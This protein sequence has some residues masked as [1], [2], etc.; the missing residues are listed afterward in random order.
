MTTWELPHSSLAW[1]EWKRP[2]N[3]PIRNLSAEELIPALMRE[4]FSQSARA[5]GYSVCSQG[6]IHKDK[7][8]GLQRYVN[9]KGE[10]LQ[11]IRSLPSSERKWWNQCLEPGRAAFLGQ[12]MSAQQQ[13][14][15]R[16]HMREFQKN[17]D[18]WVPP[19]TFWFHWFKSG[20]GLRPACVNHLFRCW[21]V[22]GSLMLSACQLVEAIV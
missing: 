16:L 1:E 7:R 19:Q 15:P 6:S 11:W 17:L 20:L 8:F 22:W 4:C 13:F 10:S 18:A 14:S 2:P 3:C 9:S 5:R 21:C 12:R